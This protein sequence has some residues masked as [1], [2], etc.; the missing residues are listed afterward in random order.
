M[1]PKKI[2]VYHET[3]D[4]KD[5]YCNG[6]STAEFFAKKKLFGN[7]II[8]GFKNSFLIKKNEKYRDQRWF[9]IL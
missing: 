1:A 5:R 3:A 7:I 6:M 9:K 4:L 8:Y 2:C